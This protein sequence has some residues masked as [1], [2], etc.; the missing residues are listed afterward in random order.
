M[1]ISSTSLLAAGATSIFAHQGGWDEILL[2]IVPLA[3][4]AL[5]LYL[6]NRRV[7]NK[8]AENASTNANAEAGTPGNKSQGSAAESSAG[9]DN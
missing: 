1:Y 9:S 2:V 5:F 8:L 3:V 4:I 6:A 7:S